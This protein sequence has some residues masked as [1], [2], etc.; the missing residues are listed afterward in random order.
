MVST[1][2]ENKDSFND[3]PQNTQPRLKVKT[4]T[5]IS[6]SLFLISAVVTTFWVLDWSKTQLMPF[7]GAYLI[8]I[9]LSGIYSLTT[10][11]YA[12]KLKFLTLVWLFVSVVFLNGIL[13]DAIPEQTALMDGT[14]KTRPE[15]SILMLPVLLNGF[16]T[17]ILLLHWLWLGRPRKIYK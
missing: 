2:R 15:Q 5:L 17:L 13:L 4:A 3:Y 10:S 12:S 11:W 16:S 9:S 7:S 14:F 8:L 6:V 1:L